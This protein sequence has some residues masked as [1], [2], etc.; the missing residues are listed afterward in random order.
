MSQTPCLVHR[1]HTHKT[2]DHTDVVTFAKNLCCFG[3]LV[4]GLV[5]VTH[6]ANSVLRLC[7]A[8]MSVLGSVGTHPQ[9]KTQKTLMLVRTILRRFGRLVVGL[10]AATHVDNSGLRL[11]HVAS[12]VLDT[13]GTHTRKTKDQTDV[14]TFAKDPYNVGLLVFGIVAVTHVAN[15]VLRLCH[16]ANPVLGALGTHPQDQKPN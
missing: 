7:H 12:S 15:S 10:V 4:F 9:D 8:A 16:V 2:K 14:G 3:I 1:E 13:L 11:G 6:V 5:A